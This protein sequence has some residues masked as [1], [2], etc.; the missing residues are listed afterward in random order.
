[1]RGFFSF[2]IVILEGTFQIIFQAQGPSTKQNVLA[3]FLAFSRLHS[4]C[5][6]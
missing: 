2:L 6:T 1:M 3:D 5:I 4:S